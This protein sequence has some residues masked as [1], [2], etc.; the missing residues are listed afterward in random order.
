MALARLT[1][2]L[3][4]KAQLAL[5]PARAA[6][7]A[8]LRSVSDQPSQEAKDKVLDPFTEKLNKQAENELAA[9]EEKRLG[10]QDGED[11]VD[12][13]SPLTLGR[14]LVSLLQ[15]FTW[16]QA[17]NWVCICVRWGARC[18]RSGPRAGEES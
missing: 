5:G 8:T 6:P 15:W 13:R 18:R 3:L 4:W 10:Q 14:S 16:S 17:C 2:N 7:A 9:V 12:V 1:T 11:W